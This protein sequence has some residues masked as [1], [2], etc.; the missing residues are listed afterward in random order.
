[1]K[2]SNQHLAIGIPCSFPTVPLSF[3]YS[4]V[5]M[6]R[7]NFTLIHADNGPIDT[8]RNDIV[9]KAL[10]IGATSLIMLDTDMIYHPKTIT[11]LLSHNLQIV[12][13]LCFGATHH[14]T[15]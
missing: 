4:F 1:M 3:F 13:A 8:L 11:T 6:E 2:V 12:G 9:E 5:H 14:L 10:T 15:A 7:P